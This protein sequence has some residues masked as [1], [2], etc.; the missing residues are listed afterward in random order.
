MARRR[1][2]RAGAHSRI[3]LLSRHSGL[4]RRRRRRRDD[5]AFGAG[6]PAGEGSGHAPYPS[7]GRGA[8][9]NASGLA[10]ARRRSEP[11]AAAARDAREK[12]V[13]RLETL[14]PLKPDSYIPAC[15]HASG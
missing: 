3:R 12:Q 2:D 13:S 14:L 9:P 5:A 1:G 7:A 6:K 11:V 10:R 8:Q 4:R 15:R